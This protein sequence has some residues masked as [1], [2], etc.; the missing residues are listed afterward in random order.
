MKNGL[1]VGHFKKFLIE[2]TRKI[3]NAKLFEHPQELLNPINAGSERNLKKGDRLACITLLRYYL[4]MRYVRNA[5]K[6]IEDINV[7]S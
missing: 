1:A 4:R 6:S 5:G 2:R 7:V 3:R